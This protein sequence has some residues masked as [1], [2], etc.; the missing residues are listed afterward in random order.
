[1]K[2][3]E[4]R[5]GKCL[6]TLEGHSGWVLACGYSPDGA[7]IVS[8]AND[9]TVKVWEARTGELCMTL[10]NAPDSQ[11]AVLDERHNRILAASP[12]AWRYLGWRYF[13]P[14]ANRLRI[15]PAEH[16]GPLPVGG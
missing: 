2:V 14:Q 11:T 13:D 7:Y 4:A 16:F 8:G 1:M 6:R 12:G 3:W 15:L 10:L 9:H 5:S